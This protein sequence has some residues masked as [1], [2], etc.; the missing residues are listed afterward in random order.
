[1]RRL[2]GVPLLA[3]LLLAG[4]SQARAASICDGIADNLVANCGFETGDFTSW[5]L[6]GNDVP[7]LL[8]NL[9]GVEG[10]DPFDG[11]S[12]HSGSDQ[13]YVADL[14]ANSTTLSQIIATIPGDQYTVTWFLAQDTPCCT[15]QP[16]NSNA[17]SVSFDGLSLADLTDV[18]VGGYTEYSGTAI[19]TG[20][21]S[22][23]AFTLGDDLG[24]FLLDDVSVTAAP[25]TPT[26]EPSTW[27]FAAGCLLLGAI[28]TQTRR[29][30]RT[31]L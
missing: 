15:G 20:A 1:M 26:P 6:S 17:F 28:F 13:A 19:A 5:S 4:L 7:L 11:I 31:A 18:P 2:S 23:L 9:Y 8:G 22:L 27:K 30:R 25:V 3:L 29:S 14:V 24:E 21:S 16:P 10:V 12:P